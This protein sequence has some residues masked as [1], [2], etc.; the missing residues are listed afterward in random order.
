[1]NTDD[2][3]LFERACKLAESA[4]ANYNVR[5]ATAWTLPTGGYLTIAK[6]DGGKS[7]V[8]K[9]I[10][11]NKGRLGNIHFYLMHPEEPDA[12]GC[13]MNHLGSVAPRLLGHYTLQDMIF[14]ALKKSQ[15]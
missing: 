13:R 3:L 8:S 1:M 2:T 14:I 9:R 15:A 10:S 4:P 11:G 7:V 6:L 5:A 12:D